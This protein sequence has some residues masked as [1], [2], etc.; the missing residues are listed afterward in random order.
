M[1]PSVARFATLIS[2]AVISLSPASFA[3]ASDALPAAA[4]RPTILSNFIF[5]ISAS[6][7]PNT[8]PPIP[9]MAPPTIAPCI[10]NA[11]PA[12]APPTAPLKAPAPVPLCL[13]AVR[14][15]DL[16][17]LSPAMVSNF[18]PVKAVDIASV[19]GAAI[20]SATTDAMRPAIN[21]PEAARAPFPRPFARAPFPPP[22]IFLRASIRLSAGATLPAL[23]I[24]MAAIF[25][26]GGAMAWAI[27]LPK[28]LPFP[29]PNFAIPPF[30]LF[31][32]PLNPPI[33]LSAGVINMA[34][35]PMLAREDI[36]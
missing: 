9:P 32:A 29:T 19:I 11:E 23:A 35:M 8:A 14:L 10:P 13:A 24:C 21:G 31:R 17:P 27:C 7:L 22:P 2:S 18:P 3:R 16:F 30:M 28:T 26:V 12:T 20:A 4:L 25:D 6:K 36:N 15:S 33:S 1:K 5:S 34:V